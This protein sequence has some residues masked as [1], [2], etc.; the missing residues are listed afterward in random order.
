M[1]DTDAGAEADGGPA[2]RAEEAIAAALGDR[3]SRTF[4]A[5]VSSEAEA[6]RWARTDAPEGA[7]V[8]GQHQIGLRDRVGNPWPVEPAAGLAFS[9]VLHPHLPP[10][11][12]G[13]LYLAGIAAML[14]SLPG[15]VAG[16]VAVEWPDTLH[17]DGENMVGG[18]VTRV[19]SGVR[20]IDWC[21]V[22]FYFVQ[23]DAARA[24]LVA[25]TLRAFDE[26]WARPDATLQGFYKERCRT[27]GRRVRATFMPIGPRSKQVEG[28]AVDVTAGGALVVVTGDERKVGLQINDI[29][30]LEYLNE[31]GELESPG[32]S[33]PLLENWPL[34]GDVVPPSGPGWTP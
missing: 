27:I 29:G 34:L 32:P 17:T 4:I 21:V 18:V 25:A 3:P 16:D 33:P 6:M 30:R 31:S 11:R 14:D 2:D 7:V 24:P 5:V 12:A 26:H 19:S 22:T 23:T 13:R 10:I 1:T 20:G 15:D 8:V 9:V 28:E